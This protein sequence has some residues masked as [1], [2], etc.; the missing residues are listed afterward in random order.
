MIKSFFTVLSVISLSFIINFQAL[1]QDNVLRFDGVND[2]VNLNNVSGQL[3]GIPQYTV[4]IWI[5][6]DVN[7]VHQYASIFAINE[8]SGDL[9]RCLFRLGGPS[10][11]INANGRVVFNVP[12]GSTNNVIVGNID[13]LDGQCH[14]VAYTYNSGLSTLYVDGILQGTLNY[15][16]SIQS[17]DRISLGQEFDAPF[18]VI[19]QMYKGEMDKLRIWN[20][21]KSQSEIQ[22]LMNQN[23]PG[24][25]LNFI[26]LYNFDQGVAGGN[27][28]SQT[29]L[30][31]ATANNLNG[32]L[33]NFSLTGSVSNFVQKDCW[34]FGST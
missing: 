21:A 2:Y 28:L 19:S 30:V 8:I 25:A 4:E 11:G 33:I 32:T 18:D 6:P 1:S 10:D 34:Q 24:S 23:V 20:V 29:T 17:S 26:A 7:Q 12:V 9:N 5:K 14:Y 27:N 16:Y 15:P 22:Q 3:T 13:V 31:D